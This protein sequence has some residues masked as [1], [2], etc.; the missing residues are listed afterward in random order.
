WHKLLL[1]LYLNF[2]RQQELMSPRLK[3]LREVVGQSFQGEIPAWFKTRYR[4]LACPM[5]KW[6]SMLMTNIRMLVLFALLF[7]SQ[8]VYSFCFELIPFNL[9]FVYLLF[10]EGNMAGSLLKVVASPQSST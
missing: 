6:W 10:R 5:L 9:L 7:I 4:D 8:P 2:T 3:M 1:A